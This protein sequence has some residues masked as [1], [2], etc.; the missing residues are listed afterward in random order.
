[1]RTRQI[2]DQSK[3]V[4]NPIRSVEEINRIRSILAD[5]PRDLLLFDIATHT[6]IGM[7]K[8]LSLRV[9]DLSG[10]KEG[11]K[12][13]I[14]KGRD[15]KYS[16]TINRIIFDTFNDY[17]KKVRPKP[18]DYLFKSKK[19]PRPLN[20][21]SAS[22]M[23]KGWFK[24]AN[25]K[26]CYGAISL[27]KTSEIAHNKAPVRQQA[28]ATKPDLIF[29]PIEST[30][31]QGKIFKELL[32]AIITHKIPPGTKLTTDGIARTFGVSQSP[33]RGALNW[34]EARGF[35]ISKKKNG[36]IVRELTAKELYDIIQ[37]RVILETGAVRLACDVCSDETLDIMESIIERSKNATDFEELDQLNR[38]FHMT[39]PRDI[40]NP[41]LINMIS[42][43]YDRFAP[44]AALTYSR[45]G[46]IPDHNLE[47]V[48]TG[49]YIKIL[50][51][52][53]RKDADEVTKFLE[54]MI[55]RGT[56]ITEEIIKKNL[57]SDSNAEFFT[58]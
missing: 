25:V 57:G 13:Y 17:L 53:R 44:Y 5:K 39:I 45:L 8:L 16:F 14:D 37:I 1:M 41:M 19:G 48:D 33:V 20:L 40:N 42:D 46:Y 51:G 2:S 34:L 3:R 21:S 27:R 28:A 50:E 4:S 36:S 26:G 54:M 18:D 15:K 10:I 38:L 32:N 29:E 47:Q 23:I 12:A 58:H 35:I 55:L 43:L 49:Y 6:G 30:T 31:N 9:S 52:M 22:N 56:A 7:Q 24:S 11:Q